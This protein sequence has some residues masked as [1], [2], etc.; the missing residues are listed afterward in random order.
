MRKPTIGFPPGPTQTKLYKYRGWLETGN[1]GNRKKKNCTIC[2]AKTNALISFA[3]T[4]KLIC[5]FVFAYAKSW[6][7]HDA[8]QIVVD[9]TVSPCY[10]YSSL[11]IE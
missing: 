10:V 8:A 2:V 5:A 7:S 1:F 3:I 6:F 11:A 9:S 4:A